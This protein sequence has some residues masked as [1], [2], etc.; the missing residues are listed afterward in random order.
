MA[1]STDLNIP[2]T[3]WAVKGF[4]LTSA[5]GPVPQNGVCQTTGTD[6][7]AMCALTIANQ[8]P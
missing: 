5:I 4:G 6:P 2:N 8:W 3:T 1:M 7:I